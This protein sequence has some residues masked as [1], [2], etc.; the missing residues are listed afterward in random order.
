ME[1]FMRIFGTAL[2]ALTLASPAVAQTSS[3]DPKT[4][5]D[6]GAMAEPKSPESSEPSSSESKPSESNN[7]QV[8]NE[9]NEKLGDASEILVN[10]AGRVE[11]VIV[12]IADTDPPQGEVIVPLERLKESTDDK[13]LVVAAT[14]DELRAMPK[15]QDVVPDTRANSKQGTE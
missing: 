5:A 12:K 9:E 14:K 2:L 4:T 8:Y 15:L 13:R 10:S 1:I 3:I 7:V 6:P 11:G